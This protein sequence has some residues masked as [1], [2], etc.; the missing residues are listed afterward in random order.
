MHILRTLP[1]AALLLWA[2]AA[3]AELSLR[4]DPEVDDPGTHGKAARFGHVEG[5]KGNGATVQLALKY[6][7]PFSA[8]QDNLIYEP[9]IALVIN[10]NRATATD[11]K[12]LEL[13]VNSV[14]G[15]IT[16][17]SAWLLN[18]SLG[19]AEDRI[20]GTHSHE[21]KASAELVARWLRWGVGYTRGQ[22]GLYLRPQVGAYWL[23]T[24]RTD[25]AA[26]APVGTAA[27]LSAEVGADLFLPF[28]DRLRITASA[29]Y[30]KDAHASGG[31]TRDSYEKAT[32][33]AEYA[34]YDPKNPPKG[35]T[36]L[37]LI[38]ERSIGRD[39]LSTST[40]KKAM[41]GI[42]LGVKL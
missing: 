15:D 42:F 18:A 14:L 39:V 8:L 31:R 32:I 38:V 1:L 23:R 22:W 30:A 28:A 2:G 9:Y 26:K 27:G 19:T 25:D 34:F 35:K 17:R 24:L 7:V 4:L 40:E 16:Q 33:G 11:K 6:G 21:G 12:K 13:G 29:R 37:S 10:D 5:N 36:L 3:S 41:T 20:V